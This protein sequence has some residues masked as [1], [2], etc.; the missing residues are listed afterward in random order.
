VRSYEIQIFKGGKWEFDSHFDDRDSAMSD[1]D[2]LAADLR[3]QGGRVLKENYDQ[4][5]NVATCDVIFTRMRK[6]NGP[7]D[8]R[9]GPQKV[10]YNKPK[11]A[12]T[13][14]VRPRPKNR[15]RPTKKS[16]SPVLALV[17]FALIILVGGVATMFG[18]GGFS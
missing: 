12:G 13:H 1:A 16:G 5:T 18:L 11:P 3:I 9:Q 14:G 8:N 17:T 6:K 2:Q 15:E 7:G 4:D 10:S